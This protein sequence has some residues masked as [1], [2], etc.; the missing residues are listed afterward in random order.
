MQNKQGFYNFNLKA[1]LG[2]V[3]AFLLLSLPRVASANL[4]EGE[5]LRLCQESVSKKIEVFKG[6]QV[7]SENLSNLPRCM[8]ALVELS[9]PAMAETH[10]AQIEGFR[11]GVGCWLYSRSVIDYFNFLAGEKEY[12]DLVTKGV[13]ETEIKLIGEHYEGGLEGVVRKAYNSAG[14][15]WFRG[16]DILK[17]VL[18]DVVDAF[19]VST[20]KSLG[21]ESDNPIIKE[22]SGKYSESLQTCFNVASELD[23]ILFCVDQLKFYASADTGKL[24]LGMF[25]EKYF[26]KEVSEQSYKIVKSKIDEEYN[27][28]LLTYYFPTNDG[29]SFT[30]KAKACAY[31]SMMSGFREVVKQTIF[32]EIRNA[33]GNVS[34]REVDVLVSRSLDQCQNGKVLNPKNRDSDYYDFMALQKVE[35]IVSAT[36]TCKTSI[37]QFLVGEI[38]K[39]KILK[40]SDIQEMVGEG[41]EKLSEDVINKYYK[42]CI[43]EIKRAHSGAAPR[44]CANYL[45]AGSVFELVENHLQNRVKKLLSDMAQL[46]ISDEG[47]SQLMDVIKKSTVSCKAS[48]LKSM[49]DDYGQSKQE[50]DKKITSCL[51]IGVVAAVDTLVE[52]AFLKELDSNRIIQKYNVTLTDAKIKQIT[53]DFS[54]CFSDQLSQFTDIKAL[55]SGAGE[56]VAACKLNAIIDVVFFVLDT[57]LEHELLS[58]GLS[59]EQAFG[60]IETYKGRETN[61]YKLIRAAKSTEEVTALTANADYEVIKAIGYNVIYL[62]IRKDTKGYLTKEKTR[63]FAREAKDQVIACAATKPLGDCQKEVTP[64]IMGKIIIFLLPTEVGKQFKEATKTILTNQQRSR[65]GVEALVRWWVTPGKTKTGKALVDFMAREI[66]AGKSISE[67]QSHPQVRTRIFTILSTSKRFFGKLLNELIQPK[68]TEYKRNPG[69]VFKKIFMNIFVNP[70]AYVWEN[71]KNT[72]SGRGVENEVKSILERIIVHNGKFLSSDEAKI[73]DLVTKAAKEYNDSLGRK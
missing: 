22:Y 32:P 54:Q 19:I 17:V 13:S 41:A 38:A 60:V 64:Q 55:I 62:L 63:D 43:S 68:L 2:I 44:D 65:L 70:K 45:S 18:I 67:V 7:R 58:A 37:E 36:M 33:I 47:I 26:S 21:V 3:L 28:C 53:G 73:V 51:S 15:R 56:S 1:G 69:N 57:V 61:L 66:S 25:G 50:A 4:A 34:D 5:A 11:C 71:I 48:V 9:D 40:N 30:E 29:E 42:T 20:L 46:E 49:I 10:G 59:A 24:I 35:T 72:P 23:Q 39:L 52:D 27:S 31:S 6:F 8:D 16:Y 14:F 12:I